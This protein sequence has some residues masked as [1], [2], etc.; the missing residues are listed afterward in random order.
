M[1]K[2]IAVLV[3]AAFAGGCGLNRQFVNAVDSY[4]TVILP[5]YRD[6]VRADPNLSEESRRQRIRTANLFEKLVEE[7]KE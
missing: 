4:V 1:R 6:Y 3:I 2:L 5:E 7:A